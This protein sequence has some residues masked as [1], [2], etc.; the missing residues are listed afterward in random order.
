MSYLR[1]VAM[2]LW[3][4]ICIT[5]ALVVLLFTFN[6]KLPLVMARVIWSPGILFLLSSKT[7]VSGLENIEKG[8]SYI[9][10]SNHLSYLDIPALF[11]VLPLNLHFIAKKELKKTLFI[12]WFMRAT[13][14]IFIDRSNNIEA[15][16]NLAEAAELIRLGKTVLIFPEGTVSSDGTIQRF[17]KG[18][19]NLAMHSGVE[20]LPL[21]IKGTDTIWPSNSNTKFKKGTINVNIGA[22]ISL[23]EMSYNQLNEVM[24]DVKNKVSQLQAL[25]N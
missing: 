18:G 20:I 16:K 12:G 22:P 3:T 25:N 17:K 24:V 23:K 15:R 10:I 19:F 21:S 14:M 2:I 1:L 6:K 7:K 9:L 13:G 4:I 5:I 11:K 8:K